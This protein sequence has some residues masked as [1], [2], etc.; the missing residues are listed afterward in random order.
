MPLMA[1]VVVLEAIIEPSITSFEAEGSQ[2]W[3]L[4]LSSLDAEPV[5]LKAHMSW[6]TRRK[7]IPI[8]LYH[9]HLA[10]ISSWKVMILKSVRC[11]H[12]RIST[13]MYLVLLKSYILY[14]VCLDHT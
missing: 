7:V 2:S 9:S 6:G 10:I 4:T 14:V 8:T 13:C 1:R 5:A 3:T 12:L 11:H